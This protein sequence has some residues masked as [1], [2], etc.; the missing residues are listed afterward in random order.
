MS[1]PEIC[2]HLKC[3][4]QKVYKFIKEIRKDLDRDYQGLKDRAGN[5]QLIQ[6]FNDKYKAR[7]KVLHDKLDTDNPVANVIAAKE[8]REND[9]DHQKFLQSTGILRDSQPTGV[10]TLLGLIRG[11]ESDSAQDE[12][13]K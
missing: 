5:G 1:V 8:L 13:S 9:R 4:T 10:E 6:E 11:K 7:T 2:V 3:N 12:P